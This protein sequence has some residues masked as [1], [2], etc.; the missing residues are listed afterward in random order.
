MEAIIDV[1]VT[2]SRAFDGL[3]VWLRDAGIALSFSRV[4]S[5]ARPRLRRFGV[6]RDTDPVYETNRAAVAALSSLTPELDPSERS[7]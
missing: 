6:V 7:R 3:R 2:G 1:D 4:R 5:S